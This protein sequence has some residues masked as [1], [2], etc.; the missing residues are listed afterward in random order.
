MLRTQARLCVGISCDGEHVET[1]NALYEALM[2]HIYADD[3]KAGFSGSVWVLHSCS[4]AR[5]CETDLHVHAATVENDGT[6][7]AIHLNERCQLVWKG[8]WCAPAADVAAAHVVRELTSLTSSSD[9]VPRIATL[10]FETVLIFDYF[11]LLYKLN[12]GVLVQEA[13]LRI[14]PPTRRLYA[15][16][17][18]A[19]H[20][21][22]APGSCRHGGH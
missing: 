14:A 7:V 22:A 6:Y 16:R 13:G 19:W 8:D 17:V 15:A 1:V 2:H 4:Q 18:P 21:H 12:V 10:D 3:T 9:R 20:M 5:Y 11:Q